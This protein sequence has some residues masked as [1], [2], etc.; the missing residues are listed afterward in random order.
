LVPIGRR[1]LDSLKLARQ[2]VDAIAENKGEDVLLLDIREIS[3]LTDYFVIASTTSERQAAAII[4]EIK[5]RAKKSLRATPLNV[6]GD[7]ASQWVVLDY[8]GVV[9]HLL[10]QEMRDYYDL[11]GLWEDAAVVLRML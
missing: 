1:R 4:D 11:E 7:T 3:I 8:G 5:K 6:D 9:V 2:I 10:T